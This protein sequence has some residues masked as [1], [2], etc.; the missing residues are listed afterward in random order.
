[1]TTKVVLIT[2]AAR[3]LGAGMV[4]HF[5][6]QGMNV[7]LHY[8]T[9]QSEAQAL[10]EAGNASRPDSVLLLPAELT[11]VAAMTGM[12]DAVAAHWGRLDLLINN[13]SSFYPTPVGTG[14]EAAWVD[15]FAS[16]A[17]APYFLS[18]AAWP[19]LEANEGHIINI[20]D[21]H[22]S[23]PLRNYTIYCMAKAALAMLTTCLAKE[24]APK[25]RVNAI[26]PGTF[27]WPEKAAAVDED[28]KEQLLKKIPLKRQGSIGDI[29]SA[30]DYLGNAPYV[31]GETLTVDGGRALSA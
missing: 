20:T 29:L 28:M 24:L 25:V 18:Q 15:L 16:N 12:I 6:Q 7:A 26:A 13:A 2:G 3:R 11:E 17:K 21:I 22:A 9:S 1:M 23:R 19:L 27:L 10:A 4:R 8:R 5:H 31:T 14:T 30:I